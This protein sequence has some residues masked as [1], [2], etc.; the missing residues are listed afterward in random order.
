MLK[1]T[2]DMSEHEPFRK[3]ILKAVGI[4][5]EDK[6]AFALALDKH[7]PRHFHSLTFASVDEKYTQAEKRVQRLDTQE[8]KMYL[9]KCKEI[10]AKLRSTEGSNISKKERVKL[11]NKYQRMKKMIRDSSAVQIQ[12]AWRG[13]QIR[14]PVLSAR[15][16]SHSRLML[17]Q[18]TIRKQRDSYNRPQ[19]INLM[20]VEQMQDDKAFLKRL[21]NGLDK[22]FKHKNG[23]LPT[24]QEKEVYRPIYEEYRAIKDNINSA[25]LRKQ[26]KNTSLTLA[27][28]KAEKRILQIRLNKF[29]R[30][31][32]M[33]NG[34]KIQYQRD[35][36]PVK[37]EFDRYLQLKTQILR[38]SGN[39]SR[40]S[41]NN[42]VSTTTPC[43]EFPISTD[44]SSGKSS[45]SSNSSSSRIQNQAGLNG[46]V[47]PTARSISTLSSPRLSS[48][49]TF[50]ER[51]AG[52][53]S[54]SRNLI[55]PLKQSREEVHSPL[56]SPPSKELDKQEARIM[57]E[58][59]PRNRT[60]MQLD[61]EAKR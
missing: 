16:P 46:F 22:A 15:D 50:V 10:R 44:I 14:R 49:S 56:S 43:T 4:L 1:D 18:E 36:I 53:T 3:A 6:E 21:L 32:R 37:E 29:E 39:E 5:F 51:N 34:R 25:T 47:S 2:R 57:H 54:V 9:A 38:Y 33:K 20:T 55:S 48:S 7:L 8:R 26:Q 60:D 31:F 40:R 17:A 61:A 28:I 52:T 27:Q 59:E 41:S 12:A 42:N 35:I 30:Q 45:S 23:R 11:I 19:D 58:W 13:Y 24:K